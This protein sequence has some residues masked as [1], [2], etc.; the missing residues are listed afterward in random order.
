MAKGKL[1]DHAALVDIFGPTKIANELNAN[2]KKDQKPLTPQAVSMWRKRGVSVWFR[3][4]FAELLIRSGHSVPKGF[5]A[6]GHR[7]W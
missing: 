7:G 5:T 6:S 3:N 1:H 4:A 2:K